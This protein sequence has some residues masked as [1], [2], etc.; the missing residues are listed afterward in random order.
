M[1]LYKTLNSTNNL[2]C[3]YGKAGSGKTTIAMQTARDYAQE[4]KKTIFIDSEGGF[5]TERFKQLAGKNYEQLLE[6]IFVFTI[7][8]FKDQQEKIKQLETLIKQGK[9]SLVIVDTLTTYYRRLV[10]SEPELANGML[11]SQLRILKALSKT[12]PVIITGQVYSTMETGI[13]PTGG[14]IIEEP[15]DQLIHL[16]KEPRI[17]RTL[18]PEKKELPFTI[19]DEGIKISQDQ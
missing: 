12:I 2:T 16:E 9:F 3:I 11:N 13:R 19:K 7:K 18:K 4:G 17:I 10:N 14:K 15:S 5:S 6:Y 8:G 1:Q